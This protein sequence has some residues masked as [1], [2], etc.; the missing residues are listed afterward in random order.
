MKKIVKIIIGLVLVIGVSSCATKSPEVIANEVQ[1]Q[2][3]A[4]DLS[5]V[6]VSVDEQGVKVA[7][8]GLLFAADSAELT[9]E[10]TM[11]LNQL[12]EIIK[13]YA[14]HKVII[15]GHTANVGDA[16]SIQI[17]SEQRAQAVANYLISMHDIKESKTTVVGLGASKPIESNDTPEGRAKNRR[18]E[19]TILN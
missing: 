8:S 16:N 3:E 19:I 13:T 12:G 1:E 5:D 7:T 10:I 4:S 18:V 15:E 14:D 2:I 6:S 9:P 11:Q 17:L